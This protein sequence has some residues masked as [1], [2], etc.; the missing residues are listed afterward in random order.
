L[1]EYYQ[2]SDLE[3]VP[4]PPGGGQAVGNN[5]V[6]INND[7][8]HGQD[9]TIN[10]YTS[11]SGSGNSYVYFFYQ[12]ANNWYRLNANAS[13]TIFQKDVNGTISQ[14]GASGA[15]AFGPGRLL[16]EWEIVVSHTGTLQ[17]INNGNTLDATDTPTTI[18]NVTDSL[19][20]TSGKIGLGG[21]GQIPIWQNFN[22]TATSGGS[23]ASTAP[24]IT[25]GT[26]AT[27]PTGT[28]YSYQITATNSPTSFNAL[29]LPPGLSINTSTGAIS[30]TPT[31]PGF[32]P[33]FISATNANGTGT[34][35]LTINTYNSGSGIS[36]PSAPTLTA[37]AGNSSV[38]LN[39][40]A[41]SGGLAY[42]V[43]RGTTSGGESAVAIT[44]DVMVTNFVD[45]TAANGTAYYYT[46]VAINDGGNSSNSN[47]VSSTPSVA[48][49]GGIP[50]FLN[51][52]FEIPV[53]SGA[54]YE[55]SGASW[56]FTNNAGIQ[57]NGSVY[58][59]LAVIAP[60]GN[61]TAFLQ[62]VS[63]TLGTMTQTVNFLAG[64]FTISFYGAERPGQSQPVLITVDGTSIGTY[65]PTS[66]SFA[67]ITTSPFTVTAGNHTVEFSTTTSSGDNTTFIDLV[68]IGTSSGGGSPPIITSSTSAS[69]TMGHAFS[70]QI[71]ASNSPTSYNAT[72]LPAGLS[73][74]TSTGA[75]TGIPTTSGTSSV[76]ISATNA[77]GTGSAT[78]TVTIATG[79]PSITS[80]TSASGTVGSAFSYQI[81][82][83]N[84]PT[85]YNATG[86][87]GGLSVNTSTGVIS[88]TPTA[89]GTDSITISATNASGTGSATLTL[90]IATGGSAPSI[91]SSTTANGTVGSA[92]SYQITASNSPTSY[93]ATGL[94]GGL[95]VNT[96]TGVI[97][98]TPT[99]AGN[100][101][102]TIS[103]TN[104]NGTG[105]STL[106]LTISSSGGNLI[107]NGTYKVL[108]ESSSLALAVAGTT[109]G[110]AVQQQTYTGATAQQWV[111]NNLGSN[112]VEMTVSGTSEALEVPGSSTSPGTFLDVSSYTGGTNQ[113]WTI[114][115]TTTTGFYEIVNVNS[116]LEVNVAYNSMTSGSGICQYTTGNYAN[117]VWSFTSTTGGSAP[118][119][120][121]STTASGTVGTP[122]T[123]AITATN[124]PTSYNAT[125]LPGGLSVNTGNG[126]ISGTPTTSGTSSV[127]ISAT[128]VGGTGTATLTLTINSSSG[129]APSIT[130]STS[131]SG[132][133]GTAFSYQITA[134]NSPTSYNATG[135]PGGLSVNTTNGVISGTPTT[136]GTSTVTISA[137]NASGTGSAMM[138]LTIAS[139]GGGNLIANGTYKIVADSSSLALAATGTSSGSAVQ[140]PRQQCRE[141]GSVRY[142]RSAGRSGFE[143]RGRRPRHRQLHR[144]HE[145]AMDPCLQ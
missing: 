124:A 25:S 80:S 58:S 136:A 86:L 61:Q 135:L 130:S 17:F 140:Q 105:S 78:L 3:P 29:N 81:T 15:Q 28:S 99:T 37:T 137:T 67:K 85:S 127:T 53:T 64:T 141:S 6:T 120:N 90:T 84:S 91:T 7:S 33:V 36:A 26:L 126:V 114:T 14:I 31:T 59:G 107:A 69:G 98:G 65:T 96:S 83:S 131:A 22:F 49:G 88:G 143:H 144:R 113:K 145:S 142:K 132:T 117:G 116:G 62:G 16:Q 109:N 87:P 32:Y 54:T 93:N 94:P 121:S 139:G 27:I 89:A 110:S 2:D 92:F 8:T 73:V 35:T 71:T 82:A 100:S 60:N 34:N 122:F 38:T 103:A 101:S 118:V 50:V 44:T 23:P 45:T 129:S 70:Y 19:S 41:P 46:V 39:W 18:L 138:T 128:N 51:P 125:G 134:S 5:H 104:A 72:G 123:Y 97:S 12:N 115:S 10:V 74:N 1:Y 56:T 108:A 57:D 66:S 9:V 133:V 111:V 40:N 63:G 102:I 68:T 76:T 11:A 43:Y 75:I 24:A 106:T 21:S 119:I 112:V 20:F 79:A 4:A 55:P 30:G 77:N 47:E 13:S 52:S 95:S 42:N 48:A